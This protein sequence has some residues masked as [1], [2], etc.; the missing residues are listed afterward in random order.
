M[1][2]T[3]GDSIFSFTK[4]YLGMAAVEWIALVGFALLYCVDLILALHHLF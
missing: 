3:L 4:S 1:L 2:M